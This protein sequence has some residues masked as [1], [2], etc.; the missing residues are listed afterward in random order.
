MP[1]YTFLTL[2]T[3]SPAAFQLVSIQYS[4]MW[5]SAGA[6][7][8]PLPTLMGTWDIV[9][10]ST[11][12]PL[13]VAAA[14]VNCVEHFSR[15]MV[16]LRVNPTIFY[17]ICKPTSATSLPRRAQRSEIPAYGIQVDNTTDS[18][19]DMLRR[20][21]DA[22]TREDP[23]PSDCIQPPSQVSAPF[24]PPIP[25]FVR[26][27]PIESLPRPILTPATRPSSSVLASAP[28]S[29]SAQ[30]PLPLAPYVA[31]LAL[32]AL[33]AQNPTLD[34]PI[35]ME[36]LANCRSVAMATCGHACSAEYAARLDKCPMCRQTTAWTTV[37][38]T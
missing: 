22:G 35:S 17:R 5:R 37:E 38:N 25:D 27:A 7:A 34:C 30:V 4:D 2:R 8:E 12:N 21:R 19:R 13:E 14:K 24:L 32:S 28:A 1:A 18:V 26:M 15:L 6:K 11:L 36:P 16:V 20:W 31:K 9:E 29:S 33:L 23:M 10:S 3:G